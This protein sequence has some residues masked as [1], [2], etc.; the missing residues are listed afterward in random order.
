LLAIIIIYQIHKWEIYDGR[1]RKSS[2]FF[3]GC[4]CICFSRGLALKA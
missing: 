4:A 1:N 2:C 3:K